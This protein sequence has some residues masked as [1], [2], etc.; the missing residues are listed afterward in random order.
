MPPT[1]NEICFWSAR[2]STSGLPT[3]LVLNMCDVARQRGAEIDV[4]ALSERLGIP[5]VSTEAH[6]RIG[7]DR[8]RQAIVDG[9]RVSRPGRPPVFPRQF[10]EECAELSRDYEF[11]G[12]GVPR[13]LVET[14]AAGR[15]RAHREVALRRGSRRNLSERLAGARDRLAQVGFRV[16]V[17]EAKV[18]YASIR[19]LLA[20][21][22]RHPAQRS[23][24]SSDRIDHLLT[25]RMSGLLVFAAVMFL[26]FQSIYTWARPLM[27]VDRGGSEIRPFRRR[28]ADAP[29][30]FAKPAL[31]RRD[32]GRRQRHPVSAAD[33]LPVSVHRD[34]GGL[35]LMARAAFL[36]DRLMARLGLSGKSFIPLM[37]SFACAIPGVMAT[38]V[39][40]NRRD[41]MVT[42]L[43]APL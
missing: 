29:G 35:R 17:A 21:V 30:R 42:M 19:T 3:V 5:V 20:G 9:L 1:S 40:E 31:R 34:A 22:L 18:R 12:K 36:M 2:C 27:D 43:I 25:H 23:T 6:R 38:R 13:Y 14:T 37:S 41:R 8:V 33:R 16:P 26:V 15:R 39:I 24:T 10:Y 28:T 32:R 4:P 11:N 7:I